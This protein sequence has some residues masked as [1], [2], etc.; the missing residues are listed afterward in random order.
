M[1]VLLVGAAQRLE[2]ELGALLDGLAPDW[3]VASAG[4]PNAAIQA[5]AETPFGMVVVGRTPGFN[6]ADLL[7][8]ARTLRP[9]AARLVLLDPFEAP[10]AR[11]IAAAHR[12]LPDTTP[13]EGLLDAIYGSL[14]LREVLDDP[15]LRSVV[16]RIERLPSPPRLY[17]ALS[18]ALEDERLGLPEA[19]QMIASDP[20]ISA[21]VLQLCNSAYFSTGR[22]TTDLRSA[23]ARLGLRQLRDIVLASEVFSSSW[24]RHIDIDG[25]QRRALLSSRLATRLLP[26]SC[27]ELG[28]TAALLADIG[29]LL[30]GVRDSDDA[31]ADPELP[32]HVDAGAYLLGLWGLP[33]PIV[34]A[35]AF[36][37]APARSGERSFWVTGAV[38]VAA[39]LTSEAGVDE[40]WLAR[41]GVADQLPQW[42]EMAA[43]LRD[44]IR[45]QRIG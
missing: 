1:D 25:V 40:A 17:L 18:R 10:T 15:D 13:A 33:M 42:R 41:L 9:D 32:S 11:V 14:E 27:A 28:A 38:H 21:K 23:V 16:G 31:D 34:E 20:A 39:A 5:L 45:P 36:H 43:D 22:P 44:G 12:F 2:E 26:A 3:R 29:L 24:P 37:R 8:Q 4:D 19:A 6:T 7:G 30:P 35:V